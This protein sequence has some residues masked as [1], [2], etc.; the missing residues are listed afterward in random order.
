MP[1]TIQSLITEAEIHQLKWEDFA[2]D[3]QA[4]DDLN[5]TKEE[6]LQLANFF[7]GRRDGLCDALP[8]INKEVKR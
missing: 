5:K 1:K 3:K 8:F 7:E 6:A 2:E 4:L